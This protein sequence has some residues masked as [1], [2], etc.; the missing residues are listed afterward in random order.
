MECK[1]GD[2][3]KAKSLMVYREKYHPQYAI[4]ISGRNFGIAE[5]IRAVPLYAVYCIGDMEE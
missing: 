3:V 5:G 2:P 1:A 4:R